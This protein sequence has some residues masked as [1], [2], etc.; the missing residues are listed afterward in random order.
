MNGTTNRHRVPH[1]YQSEVQEA[2][3][4]LVSRRR[5]ACRFAG[6]SRYEA[7]PCALLLACCPWSG[8]E[9]R[10]PRTPLR[11]VEASS[12]T[13]STTPSARGADRD[14]RL[15][16][17]TGARRLLLARSRPL[18]TLANVVKRCRGED[19]PPARR[20]AGSPARPRQ[21]PRMTSCRPGADSCFEL[22]SMSLVDS[23]RSRL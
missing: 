16:W 15:R 21:R 22:R 17:R 20:G 10:G 4:T 5:A 1:T 14:I 12:P 23:R 8:P 3:E 6:K 11:G 19:R 13:G 7:G 2:E 9:R 18:L